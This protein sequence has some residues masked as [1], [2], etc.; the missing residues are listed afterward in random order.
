MAMSL[1]HFKTRTNKV[2]ER[3]RAREMKRVGEGKREK[4]EIL[5]NLSAFLLVLGAIKS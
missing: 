3:V 4:K 1:R 5:R 2:K